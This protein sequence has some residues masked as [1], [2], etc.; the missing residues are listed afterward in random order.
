MLM[1]GGDPARADF[2]PLQHIEAFALSPPNLLT[3]SLCMLTVS[4]NFLGRLD[5][6]K[7]V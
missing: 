1:G 5:N 4:K 7:G 6:S 3:F 2:D